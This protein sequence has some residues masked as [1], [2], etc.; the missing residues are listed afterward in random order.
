MADER[1]RVQTVWPDFFRPFPAAEGPKTAEIPAAQIQKRSKNR[2][3]NKTACRP[4]TG[5][6]I[7][8]LLGLL[9][10]IFENLEICKIFSK[11]FPKKYSNLGTLV[12]LNARLEKSTNFSS[13]LYFFADFWIWVLKWKSFCPKNNQIFVKR[14]KF[15][16]F[17]LNKPNIPRTRRNPTFWGLQPAAR[18]KNFSPAA[19]GQKP[20]LRREPAASGHTELLNSFLQP[21]LGSL[22]SEQVQA[23]AAR[24]VLKS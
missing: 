13:V 17:L 1:L 9:P 8:K 19:E 3:K 24:R 16:Q 21:F 23:E 5:V 18:L 11:L 7:A 14:G 15:L 6:K 10:N 22:A 20:P 4:E 12:N 2:S